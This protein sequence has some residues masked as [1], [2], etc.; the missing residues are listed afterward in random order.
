[1]K[2]SLQRE[3]NKQQHTPHKQESNHANKRRHAQIHKYTNTQIIKIKQ[4]NKQTHN[5]TIKQS[6]NQSSKLQSKTTQTNIQAITIRIAGWTQRL[7]AFSHA[8]SKHLCNCDRL[9][10]HSMGEKPRVMAAAQPAAFSLGSMCCATLQQF[11]S[12]SNLWMNLLSGA[13][14]FAFHDLRRG[15]MSYCG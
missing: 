13:P 8:G 10:Q 6:N 15:T 7:Q 4:T 9:S 14:L 5:Q 1:M 2:R 3:T 12:R 11:T